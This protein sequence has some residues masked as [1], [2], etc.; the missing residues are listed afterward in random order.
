[1]DRKRVYVASVSGKSER[2]RFVTTCDKLHNATAILNDHRAGRAADCTT[3][4]DRF[5]GKPPEQVVA[6]YSAMVSA[7]KRR[8]VVSLWQ[9]LADTLAEL[10]GVTDSDGH[11]VWLTRLQQPS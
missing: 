9:R 1:M 3:V 6:Y 7:L 5:G 10:E 2:A 8:V 11:A 4:W